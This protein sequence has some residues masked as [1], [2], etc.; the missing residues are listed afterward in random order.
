[1]GEAQIPHLDFCVGALGLEQKGTEEWKDMSKKVREACETHGCF[2]VA[3]DKI[4]MHQR[5]EMIEKLEALFDLPE[6]TKMK[7]TDGTYLRSYLRN[8]NES[9]GI[10][11]ATMFDVAQAFTNLMWPEGN[12]SFCETLRSM[13]SKMLELSFT[14]LEMILSSFGLGKHYKSDLG[15]NASSVRLIK[16]KAPLTNDQPTIGV[17]AHTDTSILT[18]LC[19]NEVQGLEVLSKDGNWV[20]VIIPKG[21]FAVFVGDALQAWSN[22]RLWAPNHRVRMSGHEDRYSWG[23]FLSPKEGTSI[24]VPEE[25]VDTDHPLRYR[26]FIHS[27]YLSF[28]LA[29]LNTGH[30]IQD[31]LLKI[32]A[33]F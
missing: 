7:Y 12:T 6:E 10:P 18:I 31:E 33:G 23:S 29:N 17:L 25:L 16:Y 8:S 9:F 13:S 15:N 19:Q 32:Y 14:I 28:Y 26:P 5:E 11:D 2:L 1:M 27:D 21:C 30:E 4:P 22:G 3:Y 20:P 24:E